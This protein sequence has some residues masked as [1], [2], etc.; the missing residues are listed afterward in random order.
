MKLRR[1]E[2]IKENHRKF[3]VIL[4]ECLQI[5]LIVLCSA[6]AGNDY[7]VKGAPLLFHN[8]AEMNAIP[9]ILCWNC[10]RPFIYRILSI[11]IV[12]AIMTLGVSLYSATYIQTVISMCLFGLSFWYLL[13]TF[14][15][16]RWFTFIV[17]CTVATTAR[18]LL[19]Y[20]PIFFYTYDL[21][22]LFIFTL[23]LVLLARRK[24]IAFLV[25]LFFAT[26][27]K[28][29]S[30]FLVCIFAFHYRNILPRKQYLQNIAA[31]LLFYGLVRFGLMFIF[32][33]NPGVIMQSH[34]RD[35]LLLYQRA[36]N[37]GIFYILV[38]FFLLP[39]FLKWREKPLF[40]R[41]ASIIL[42]PFLVLY[43]FGGAPL[44]IRIFGECFPIIY[45]LLMWPLGCRLSPYQNAS[46]HA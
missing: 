33:N 3:L 31:Q 10:G 39:I 37:A 20:P 40:L 43:L 5:V 2:I 7:F 17:A 45:A 24:C 34:L 12:R 41:E 29:T 6:W 13:K 30:I 36:P 46:E 26:L 4:L 21:T 15:S 14:T 38:F 28:E 44:E 1:H 11:I 35:Q 8:L 19:Y 16:N 9:T 22:V 42:F 23:G 18:F 25:T 27:T 32:R